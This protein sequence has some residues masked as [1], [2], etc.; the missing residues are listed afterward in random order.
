[1][2]SRITTLFASPDLS[3]YMSK[4]YTEVGRGERP[5]DCH[6]PVRGS[7]YHRQVRC[8]KCGLAIPRKVLEELR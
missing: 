3:D 2:T 1:M 4:R 6:R 8:A 7:T 5:C